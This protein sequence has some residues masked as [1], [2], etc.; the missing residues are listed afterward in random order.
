MRIGYF[1]SIEGWGGSEIYLKSLM[2]G[3]RD[4]GHEVVLFGIGGTRLFEDMKAAGVKCVAWESASG[5][6]L[7]EAMP[8]SLVTKHEGR[9]TLV[10]LFLCFLPV[11]S[12]LFSG[13]LRI[14]WCLYKLLKKS[15]VD[16]MHVNVHGYELA[17]IACRIAGIPS[18]GMHCIMPEYDP[19]W[20][21]RYLI[22]WTGKQYS[23]VAGK[24]QACIDEWRVYCRVPE[25]KCGY[26]W[27][28]VDL[29]KFAPAE[30]QCFRNKGFFKVLAVARLHPMKGLHLLLEAAKLLKEE[31]VE[32]LIAGEGELKDELRSI[33]DKLKVTNSVSFLGQVDDMIDLYQSVDC[34]VV[35]S[36]SHESFGQTIVEAM[37]CG[38]PVV[39]SDYGPFPEI[40]IHEKTGLIFH[41][42]NSDELA[43]SIARLIGNR[44]LRK[45]LG[46]NGRRRVEKYFSRERMI[47]E[48]L[49]LYHGIVNKQSRFDQDF[50]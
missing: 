36:V 18:L 47:E 13:S 4:K 31:D 10:S 37:A 50:A 28:G 25:N 6:N 26:I 14:V 33:A 21:R 40:N 27:N 43:R 42:G 7:Q 29:G 17:G 2:L 5:V 16:V 30:G 12:R 41:S 34:V 15:G 3:V 20:F 24:S 44:S 49:S 46:E 9:H 48:T 39:T 38:V 19:Y 23:F 8:E 1:T 11:W 22:K 45:Y 32:V 35:P